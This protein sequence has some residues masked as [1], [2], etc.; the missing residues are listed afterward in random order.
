MD[1]SIVAELI[2]DADAEKSIGLSID[3]INQIASAVSPYMYD[4][5]DEM[6]VSYAPEKRE[7]LYRKCP[8]GCTSGLIQ[9]RDR[10]NGLPTTRG[11]CV[12]CKGE[13]YVA[14]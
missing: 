7:S 10:L 3:Q 13:G 2:A 6:Q 1:A 8:N 4:E 5:A 9:N 14:V 12:Y 11:Q